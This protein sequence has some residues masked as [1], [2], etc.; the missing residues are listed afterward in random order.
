VLEPSRKAFAR[1]MEALAT[2]KSYDGGDQGFLNDF[3]ADW[4][5][6]PARRR[7]PSGYNLPHFIYQFMH[8]HPTLKHKLEK[9]AKI[10]HYTV[11]KPWQS[12]STV[13]GGSEAWWNAYYGAHPELD[14]EWRRAL[15]TMEDRSFDRVIAAFVG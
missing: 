1:M 12:A 4:Y 10:I 2:T 11:Q 14:S 5:G 13:T 7:L 3:F 6:G 9:T 8:G 15:H